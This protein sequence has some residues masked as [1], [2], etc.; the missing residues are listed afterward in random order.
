VARKKT[1]EPAAFQLHI[2]GT[3][4]LLFVGA[5]VEAIV[6]VAETEAQSLRVDDVTVKASIT[7]R[8]AQQPQAVDD[9]TDTG[10]V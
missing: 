10:G 8:A 4:G 9:G 3:G 5:L 7:D 2:E 6:V 1:P